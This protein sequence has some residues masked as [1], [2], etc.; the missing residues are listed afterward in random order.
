[1]QQKT[2]NESGWVEIVNVE[3]NLQTATRYLG[4]RISSPNNLG[5]IS[6]TLRS[7]VDWFSPTKTFGYCT[8]TG[9]FSPNYAG[10]CFD[11]LPTNNTLSAT[12]R[13]WV[14]NDDLNGIAAEELAVY[15]RVGNTY[16]E[17]FDSAATGSTLGY[18]YAEAVTPGFS[19]FLAG[20]TG[21]SPTLI[22]FL[23]LAANE[24]VGVTAVLLV[25]VA[26]LAVATVGLLLLVRRRTT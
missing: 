14:L 5:T 2:Q 7:T 22:G 1:M 10:R 8:E 21:D 11:I 17:Q 18:K 24:P 20:M 12:V 13:L 23:G 6:V 9:S 15:R 16:E 19:A 3:N 26:L 25:I 4:T